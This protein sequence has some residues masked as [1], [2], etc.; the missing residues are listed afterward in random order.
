MWRKVLSKPDGGVNCSFFSAVV[1]ND[2][3][4]KMFPPLDDASEKRKRMD[5]CDDL[6]IYVAETILHRRAADKR[7]HR[8]V[9]T[10]FDCHRSFSRRFR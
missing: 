10:I 1:T 8:F 6:K 2:R 3:Q 4:T 9:C 5:G 7:H